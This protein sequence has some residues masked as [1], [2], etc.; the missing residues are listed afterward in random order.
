MKK[1]EYNVMK[2]IIFFILS[3]NT[4]ITQCL[5]ILTTT[6]LDLRSRRIASIILKPIV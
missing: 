6:P 2:M 5:R 1:G 4:T 3:D